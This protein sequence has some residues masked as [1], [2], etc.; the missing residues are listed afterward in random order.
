MAAFF[1]TAATV[2]SLF[3]SPPPSFLNQ[4]DRFSFAFG[5]KTVRLTSVAHTSGYS[6]DAKGR[7]FSPL[8]C[9][10]EPSRTIVLESDDLSV[11]H[12]SEVVPFSESCPVFLEIERLFDDALDPNHHLARCSLEAYQHIHRVLIFDGRADTIHILSCSGS[13]SLSADR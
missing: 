11:A 8:A 13:E 6:D 12:D 2:A 10:Y 7:F 9:H 3:S 4:S 1:V 5:G